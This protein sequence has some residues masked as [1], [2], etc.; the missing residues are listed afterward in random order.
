MKD[1]IAW[2]ALV[3]GRGWFKSEVVK[4]YRSWEVDLPCTKSFD[5]KAEVKVYSMYMQMPNTQIA[6]VLT[7]ILPSSTPLGR[8]SRRHLPLRV[9][10]LPPIA[11]SDSLSSEGATV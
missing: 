8:N 9:P 10:P 2:G 7:G 1:F 6:A 5:L 11:R 3:L 4:F